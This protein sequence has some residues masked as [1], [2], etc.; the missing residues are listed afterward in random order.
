[1]TLA[2]TATE[3]PRVM[4]CIGSR[5]MPA[6][7]PPDY[8][9]EKRDEGNCADWLAE[10]W[11]NGLAADV[12]T[13]APNGYV[14]TSD[15]VE[16]VKSY[17]EALDCGEMQVETT[18]SGP[19]GVWEI[20]G[21]ADHIKLAGTTLTID[22][23]KYGFRIVEPDAN[24][25]LLAHA[26]GYC[27]RHQVAPDRIVLRI[28]QPRPYHSDGPLREWSCSYEQ[29]MGYYHQ[30]NDRLTNPTDELTTGLDWCAKC[31]ALAG[32]PAARRA[33]MNAIDA[34]MI[35]FSEELP[36]DVLA[37][38][39]ETLEQAT[40][41]IKARQDAVS[42]L[43]T[44]RIKSGQVIDGYA[45]ETRYGHTKWK[46]GYTGR[47]LSALTGVDLTADGAVTP[48]EAKRRGVTPEALTAITERPMIGSKLKRIDPDRAARKMFGDRA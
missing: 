33:S 6:M 32:C 37:F 39:L 18:F 28:H 20:R 36:N 30:I 17:L 23:L 7:L 47:M 10:Q 43:M 9:H 16:H 31:H 48:A 46:T 40:G 1:M 15:M 3:L 12:G 8:D 27:I 45:L 26:I 14:V 29:L 5:N 21:R 35:A 19:G 34:S 11:F 24:W 41:M 25:T 2:I 38:E 44:H 42:E 13:K 4:R 22:D